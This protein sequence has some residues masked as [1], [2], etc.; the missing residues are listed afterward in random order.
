MIIYLYQIK[1]AIC[2][3]LCKMCNKKCECPMKFFGFF[4]LDYS[5]IEFFP[6]G[7]SYWQF[8]GALNQQMGVFL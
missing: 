5:L 2:L 1:F 3:M 4:D 8:H 6:V 7:Y